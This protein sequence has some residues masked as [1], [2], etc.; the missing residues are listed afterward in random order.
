MDRTRGAAVGGRPP[1]GHG[2]GVPGVGRHLRWLAV[3]E[4]LSVSL[5]SRLEETAAGLGV[6]RSGVL[7]RC[8]CVTRGRSRPGS[9]SPPLVWRKLAATASQG[10]THGHCQGPA[11]PQGT[12]AVPEVVPDTVTGCVGGTPAG[13]I[14]QE[15]AMLSS[16][17]YNGRWRKSVPRAPPVP[18][19]GRLGVWDC[20][21]AS[22]PE[23][24][25]GRP[26]QRGGWRDPGEGRA[27]PMRVCARACAH[28]GPWG[29]D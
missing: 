29:G 21:E 26:G 24:G 4:G 27:A 2:D 18:P 7:D 23:G 17:Y 8:R 14:F 10:L 20:V 25:G 22:V 3:A 12:E 28:V 13:L 9:Q 6:G 1:P 11:C 19:R 5:E 16:K 15:G